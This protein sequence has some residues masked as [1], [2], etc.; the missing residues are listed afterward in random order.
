MNWKD[1]LG[2]FQNIYGI[3]P[4]FYYG[5]RHYV[6]KKDDYKWEALSDTDKVIFYIVTSP[7]WLFIGIFELFGWIVDKL[8]PSDSSSNTLAEK[9][10]TEG[11]TPDPSNNSFLLIIHDV[12][13]I[14]GRGPVVSGTITHGKISI[15]D[16]LVLTGVTETRKA[17]CVGIEH[18]R[19]LVKS[20]KAGELIGLL[21][22]GVNFHDLH[23]GQSV[24]K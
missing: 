19:Q 22:K 15:G 1:I 11:V 3:A 9:N 10:I 21:L 6:L 5:F 23:V 7:I 13:E 12:F 20:A 16:L 14:Q 24:T 2:L 4:T 18:N 8:S 17:I